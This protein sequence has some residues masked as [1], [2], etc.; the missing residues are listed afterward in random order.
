MNSEIIKVLNANRAQKSFYTH[1][2]MITPKGIFSFPHDKLDNFWETYCNNIYKDKNICLGINEVSQQYMPILAD[3]DLKIDIQKLI[4]LK[5]EHISD[6]SKIQPGQ[7]I[8]SDEQLRITVK[9]Y[10][11]A[12]KKT[13]KGI[14][15]EDLTCV[16]LEKPSYLKKYNKA[17]FLSNGFH[18]HFPKIFL[19]KNDIQVFIM[20]IIQSCFDKLQLF[21]NLTEK[22]SKVID[23]GIF[24][25]PWL[26]YGSRKS[27]DS[28]PYRIS[29]FYDHETRVITA[30]EALGNY[31]FFDQNQK[32]ITAEKDIIYY[33]PRILSV[34]PYNRKVKTIN[35]SYRAPSFVT[36]RVKKEKKEYEEIELTEALSM[37]GRLLPLLNPERAEEYNEWIKIG[38]ILYN[39]T[40][41]SDEGRDL[42][43]KFSQVSDKYN[44]AKCDYYWDKM[45]SGSYSMGSL[46]YLAKQ[47]NPKKYTAL[48]KGDAKT[49]I[50]VNLKTGSHYDIAKVLH[51]LY[52]DEFV[53]ASVSNKIWYWFHDHHW[54]RIDSGVFLRNKISSD[55]LNMVECLKKEEQ[56]K[57][58]ETEK[59][60]V[61]IHGLLQPK[62]TQDQGEK[63][64][65]RS[66]PNHERIGQGMEIYLR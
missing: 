24:A 61:C 13:V 45:V 43:K 1:T 64:R 56:K 10:Q 3:I 58:N 37:I 38:W 48:I 53:C 15:D 52:T 17:T 21:D 28:E 33:L 39:V 31:I 49:E 25:N 27:I 46:R 23:N 50:K 47:D 6:S 65:Y 54:E 9:T 41:G 2:S 62:S 32:P 55:I 30:S 26:M 35:P 66:D 51:M 63:S 34:F 14:T 12:I 36:K 59:A 22:S 5:F 60:I 4:D 20:P 40:D 18:L 44:E 16:V 42:W 7:K 57:K 29:K 11:A 8:Y 19:D